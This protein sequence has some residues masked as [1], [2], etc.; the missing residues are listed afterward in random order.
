[1]I[2]EVMAG[3]VLANLTGVSLSAWFDFLGTFGGLILTFL[4][5]VE[6][7]FVLL[8]SKAKREPHEWKPSL[9]LLWGQLAS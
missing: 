9:H 4:A 8:G 3:L 1:M 5:G 7:K 6:V 2:F